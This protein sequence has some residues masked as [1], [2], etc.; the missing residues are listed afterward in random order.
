MDSRTAK[1]FDRFSGDALSFVDTWC[2]H[3][4]DDPPYSE[5][6]HAPLVVGVTPPKE[7]FVGKV[8]DGHTGVEQVT[9]LAGGVYATDRFRRD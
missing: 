1:Q 8:R 5:L 9:R 2:V 7:V 6:D 4:R 3:L